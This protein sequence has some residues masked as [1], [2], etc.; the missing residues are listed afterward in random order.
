[1]I[2]TLKKYSFWIFLM[3]AALIILI[4]SLGVA[5][6]F[7]LIEGLGF[8]FFI[9]ACMSVR[10]NSGRKKCSRRHV[11]FFVAPFNGVEPDFVR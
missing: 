8:M 1:M 2:Q 11:I 10:D 5:D 4:E 7:T 6:L 9:T 3:P